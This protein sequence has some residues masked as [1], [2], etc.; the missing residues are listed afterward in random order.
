MNKC[1][2]SISNS[3]DGEEG[4]FGFNISFSQK[5]IRQTAKIQLCIKNDESDDKYSNELM[6]TTIDLC[7][8]YDG[9]NKMSMFVKAMYAAKISVESKHEIQLSNPSKH[10]DNSS[11][12]ELQF[13]P[14]FPKITHALVTMESS[15]INRTKLATCIIK[16]RY[17]KSL[18]NEK[19]KN[20]TRKV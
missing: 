10:I 19:G 6:K 15:G 12:Y 2:Y 20:V 5:I 16:L 1:L 3:K 14:P 18:G 7:Q 8:I 17:K 9:S 4:L 11:Q 13:I